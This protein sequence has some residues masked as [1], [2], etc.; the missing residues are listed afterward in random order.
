LSI[1]YKREKGKKGKREKGKRQK[2]PPSFQADVGIEIP[3]RK[4]S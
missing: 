2:Y 3:G 4:H 1:L